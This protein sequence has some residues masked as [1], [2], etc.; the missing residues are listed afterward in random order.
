M[1]GPR[2]CDVYGTTDTVRRIRVLT[3]DVESQEIVTEHEA[4]LSTRARARLE[5]HIAQGLKPMQRSDRDRTVWEQ[6]SMPTE[7]VQKALWDWLAAKFYRN[8]IPYHQ[9]TNL[10][11]AAKDLFEMGVTPEQLPAIHKRLSK[12]WKGTMFGPEAMVKWAPQALEAKA[13]PST[14][15]IKIRKPDEDMDDFRRQAEEVF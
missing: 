5:Q 12:E 11:I 14:P 6:E 2:K 13:E 3:L 7:P 8:H 15:K 9:R 4:M 10:D 1:E